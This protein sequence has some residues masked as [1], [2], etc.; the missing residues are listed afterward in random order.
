MSR[1]VSKI[2]AKKGITDNDGCN[3]DEDD[4]LCPKTQEGDHGAVAL[5]SSALVGFDEFLVDFWPNFP[6][7]EKRGLGSCPLIGV[8]RIYTNISLK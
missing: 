6:Q 1:K 7:R 2:V 8:D 4:K 5:E 3:C